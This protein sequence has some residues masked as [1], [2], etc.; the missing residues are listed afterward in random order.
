MLVRAIYTR[1]V[2]RQYAEEKTIHGTWCTSYFLRNK[3]FF[4]VEME[5][6]NFQHLFY[7]H[8]V[9]PLKKLADSELVI[10]LRGIKVVRMSWN[11][12][13][14][15]EIIR[16]AENFSFP[17]WQTKKFYVFLKKILSVPCTIDNSLFSPQM[18]WCLDVP[19][20]FIKGFGFGNIY[21]LS[22]LRPTFGVGAGEASINGID[23]SSYSKGFFF[24]SPFWNGATSSPFPLLTR[25]FL[26]Y[27]LRIS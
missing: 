17:S 1:R 24:I 27:Y 13:S 26:K 20:F 25:P 18:R 11:F 4:F 19:T 22:V 23:N 16:D 8:F 14:F 7:F 12:E 10:F 15:H 3:T 6:W 9:K 21:Y 2:A 5:N